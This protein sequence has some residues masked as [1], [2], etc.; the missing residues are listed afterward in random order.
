VTRPREQAWTPA[1]RERSLD[2]ESAAKLKPGPD[3]S[4][5]RGSRSAQLAF[6]ECF[7]R[8]M[9]AEGFEPTV[10]NG[11]THRPTP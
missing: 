9:G 5:N 1:P 8:S 10:S 6:I 7:L 2:D 11:R 4:P 3:V